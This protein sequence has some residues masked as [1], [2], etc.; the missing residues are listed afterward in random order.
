[1]PIYL[2]R[3]AHAVDADEDPRRPLSARGQSQLRQLLRFFQNRAAFQPLQF[4]HSPLLRA[5]QTAELLA[6]GLKSQPALIE[7]SGL[8][9]DDS[10]DELADRLEGSHEP[11]RIGVVG[12]LPHLSALATLLVRGKNGAEIFD[13]KKAAIL[14]LEA[15]GRSHKKTGRALWEVCWFVTPEVFSEYQI[16]QTT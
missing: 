6:G 2:I 8:L 3:H 14:A 7:T 1:M 5:R 12:H 13:F 16:E 4:W 15:T 11:D 10:P 9:P